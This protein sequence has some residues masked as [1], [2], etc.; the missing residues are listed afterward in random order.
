MW[1]RSPLH[2]QSLEVQEQYPIDQLVTEQAL[3]IEDTYIRTRLIWATV[4]KIISMHTD[5]AR[6]KTK[7][8][9]HSIGN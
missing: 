3:N 4:H 8:M 6:F 5:P 7:H 9:R 1:R 2:F